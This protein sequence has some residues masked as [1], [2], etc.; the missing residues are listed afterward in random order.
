MAK[1]KIK[2]KDNLIEIFKV[3]SWLDD[4]RW[5]TPENYNLINFSK[6]L[7]NCEKI[8]THWICYITDRQMPYAKVWDNGGYVFS[9]LV[10]GYSRSEKA[11]DTA[12]RIRKLFLS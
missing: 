9:E 5:N 2:D 1:L 7:T 10:Y 11:K 12:K 6:D 4:M 8:L 3:V